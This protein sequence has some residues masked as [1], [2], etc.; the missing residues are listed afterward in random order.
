[1]K[2]T[3]N[4]PKRA[5]FLDRDGCLI[6][7][8]DYLSNLAD[9][10]L[11]E[12]AK[13]GLLAMRQRGFL[14]IQVTNQS[15]VARGYF[16]EDFVPQAHERIQ[17]LL[18]EARLDALYYC[19][20][21]VKGQ[22]PYDKDCDCRKPLPGMVDQALRDFS[23]D[24]IRSYM[25]GDKLADVELGL[26]RGMTPILVLTGHGEKEKEKVLAKHPATLVHADLAQAIDWILAQEAASPNP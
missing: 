26:N 19:P 11:T 5:L 6:E 13:E 7:E 1:M 8:V 14:L 18:G 17:S 10:R 16:S 22:A 21:H 3:E 12:G 2:S 15:G 25:I 4:A 24:L 20:H 9:I 23:I